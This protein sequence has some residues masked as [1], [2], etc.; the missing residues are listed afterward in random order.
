MV[1]VM[2]P[3]ILKPEKDLKNHLTYSTHFI[4][5]ETGIQVG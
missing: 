1:I 2:D 5:K 4:D 3:R